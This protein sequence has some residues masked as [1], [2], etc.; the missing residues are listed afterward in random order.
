MSN[1][2]KAA[3]PAELVDVG[4]A[5]F[6]NDNAALLDRKNFGMD[7]LDLLKA[8]PSNSVSLCFFDPKYDHLLAFM[9]YG[10][11]ERQKDRLA[12]KPMDH[13]NILEFG[14]EIARVL[15]PSGHVGL[16]SDQF[17][18][19][20]T[21][22]ELIFGDPAADSISADTVIAADGSIIYK[23]GL[24]CWDKGR[25]GMGWTFRHQS[26]YLTM[27]QKHAHQGRVVA[28][29]YSRHLARARQGKN[30][31]ARQ[32]DRFANRDH[33]C[34]YQARRSRARS[35]C[36][37]IRHHDCGPRDRPSFSRMRISPRE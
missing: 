20:A 3:T 19:C 33:R 36:W 22:P 12:L 5:D 29:R 24:C 13:M 28:A 30:P 31:S 27:F 18:L 6:A 32:A 15:K 8:I 35:V 11:K 37:R 4:L 9:K 26:E 1:P 17:I 23:V 2:R 16:W 34:N 10:N 25:I 7:G 21:H 14:R